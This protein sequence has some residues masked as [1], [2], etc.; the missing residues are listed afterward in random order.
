M[1]VSSLAKMCDE[2]GL[3]HPMHLHCNNLGMPGNVH[4][5]LETMKVLEGSRCTWPTCSSI[6]TAATT[7]TACGCVS[8]EVANYFNAH[9]NL[10]C[11]AGAVLFGN[12]VTIT[13]DGPCKNICCTSSRAGNGATLTLKMNGLWHRAVH[14]QGEQP[15]QRGAVGGGAGVAAS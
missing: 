6:P 11:D 2:L 7:G 5:T 1:I 12:A 8:I 9:K 14:V 4:T 15:G 3:P 10:T 13:A